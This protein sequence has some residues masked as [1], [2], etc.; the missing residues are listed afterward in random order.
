VNGSTI[1]ATTSFLGPIGNGTA[2]I[3]NFSKVNAST[4]TATSTI[5]PA[6]GT[7][8]VLPLQMNSSSSGVFTTAPVGGIEYDNYNMYLTTTGNTS[9]PARGFFMTPYYKRVSTSITISSTGNT[10]VIG[11]IGLNTSMIYSL[12]GKLMTNCSSTSHTES[13]YFGSSTSSL[14]TFTSITGSADRITSNITSSSVISLSTS[15]TTTFSATTAAITTGSNVS[16][17][18]NFLFQPASTTAIGLYFNTS[19]ASTFYISV[20]SYIVITPLSNSSY[21]NIGPWS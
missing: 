12:T 16:Y 9:T 19:V 18:L 15:N 2:N 20:G 1:T 5:Y 10:L 14:Y 13:L 4:I 6:A 3:G 21:I 17:D 8:T 7:T 11:S